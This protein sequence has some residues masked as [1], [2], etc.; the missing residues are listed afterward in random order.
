MRHHGDASAEALLEPW[1][2]QRQDPLLL[3]VLQSQDHLLVLLQPQEHLRHCLQPQAQL[4][5][6]LQ[7]LGHLAVPVPL[8][9]QAHVCSRFQR[10]RNY[11]GFAEAARLLF[12]L[13]AFLDTAEIDFL[14]Y[15]ARSA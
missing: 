11:S 12:L 5:M 8:Q 15:A 2:L 14:M 7:P 10:R 6:P 3:L 1:V 13:F 9:P 4:R